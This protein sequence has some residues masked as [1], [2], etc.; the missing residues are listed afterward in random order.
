[1]A[2]IDGDSSSPSKLIDKS[3]VIAAK[4]TEL[5]EWVTNNFLL[6]SCNSP[7]LKRN[8]AWC[9]QLES[10]IRGSSC[11]FECHFNGRAVN[12]SAISTRRRASSVIS[13]ERSG[14]IDTLK[15]WVTLSKNTWNSRMQQTPLCKLNF[16][17][18]FSRYSSISMTCTCARD[19]TKLI[20]LLPNFFSGI[21]CVTRVLLFEDSLKI[22]SSAIFG[23]CFLKC[24]RNL[25]FI[26]WNF[27]P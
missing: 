10:I 9:H 2:I 21:F 14:W 23:N 19:V 16:R 5:A 25:T 17:A 1:M 12:T 24:H 20:K 8:Y 27:R 26:F 13:T 4:I 18:F 3:S 22:I 11:H 7:T 15:C 6:R